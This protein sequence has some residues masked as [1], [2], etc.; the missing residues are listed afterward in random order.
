MIKSA[1]QMCV[2]KHMCAHTQRAGRLSPVADYGLLG[3][4]ADEIWL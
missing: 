4:I 2:Q 3:I 1:G